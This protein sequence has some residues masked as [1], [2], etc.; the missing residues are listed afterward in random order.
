MEIFH[1]HSWLV[2]PTQARAI[3]EKLRDL[4]VLNDDFASP[5]VIAGVDVGFE[6]EGRTVRAAVV[7]L[8]FPS[9]CLMEQAIARVPCTFPYVPGLLSF[10]E[11]PGVLAAMEQLSRLPD[12]VLCDG[13]GYAHPRRLGIASHLGILSGLPTIGVGKTRLIGS[14]D[15]PG[16]EKGDWSGLFDQGERIGSVVRTRTGIKPLFI[17]PGHKVSF[18]SAIDLTLACTIRYKL[19]ETTRA[20]HRLASTEAGAVSS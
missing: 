5:S 17:S 6:D 14:Y 4:V 1:P 7:L 12:L 8:E 13:Q 2:S 16:L 20:A 18:Q 11:L 15:E 19:P 10:R 3:Q 9:L